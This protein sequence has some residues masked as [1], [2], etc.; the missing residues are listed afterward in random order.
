M[1]LT[2]GKSRAKDLIVVF[3]LFGLVTAATAGLMG[4]WE[5]VCA[6]T[7]RDLANP[8]HVVLLAAALALIV[9]GLGPNR[10]RA[11]RRATFA[12][13]LALTIA[14]Y[15]HVDLLFGSFALTFLLTLYFYKA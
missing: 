4:R 15:A 10:S 11:L 1:D 2:P 7:R 13:M 8:M 14:W 6:R 9:W 5:D 12:A 3:G